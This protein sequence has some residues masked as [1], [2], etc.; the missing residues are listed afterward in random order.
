M[1]HLPT[2]LVLAAVLALTACNPQNSDPQEQTQRLSPTTAPSA[3]DHGQEKSRLI[4]GKNEIVSIL[5]NGMVVIC[6]RVASPAVT[7]RGYIRT[8]GVYE[9]KWLG[10]G[11]SHLLEHLVAGGSNQRRTEAQNRDLLQAIGNNSNAYTA[12]DRTACFVNTTPEHLEQAVDLV[13]GWVLGAKIT[14]A[15]FEREREVV[16][17]ELEMYEGMPD[18]VFA[19]L[20]Q[21]NRY[22]V[23]PARVPVIGCKEVIRRITRDDVY[24]YYKLAYQPNNMVFIVAGDL[25]PQ[26]M[27]RAVQK[28]V[29]DAPP[30]RAFSH[31]IE[32]E[33]LPAAPRTRLATFPNLGE[34]KLDLAFPGV[35]AGDPDEPALDLL[36]T[37]LGGGES[38]ILIQ[39]IRDKGLASSVSAGD[40]TPAYATGSFMVDMEM[41][42]DKIRAASDVALEQIEIVKKQGVSE[43]RLNRAKTQIKTSKAFARQTAGDVGEMMAV[44]FLNTGDV[45]F[46]DHYLQRVAQVT[47]EQIR[48]VAGKYLDRSRLLQTALMPQSAPGAEGLASA[49]AVLRSATATSRPVSSVEP[50]KITR[51]ELGDGTV[52]LV[53]RI[54]TAP[55]VVIRMYALGGV[56]A[57]DTA[58][59]GLGYLAMEAVPR[60]TKTRSARQ[61]A[62]FFDSIGGRLSTDSGNNA[63]SWSAICLKD[64]LRRTLEVFADVVKNPTF[65]DSEVAILQKRIVAAIDA[66]DADWFGQAMRFFRKTYFAP[67][68]SPYQFLPIGTKQNVEQ[69]TPIQAR[70]WYTQKILKSRR[71]LAIFGDVDT[72]QA[73]DL[74]AAL[75]GGIQ[76]GQW[77]ATATD[78][79]YPQPPAALPV[80]TIDVARVAVNKTANPQ[81]AVIVGFDS[82]SVPGDARDYALRVAKTMA[83]GYGYPTGYLFETLRG[84]GLVYDVQ[85]HIFYGRDRKCPGAFIVFAGCDPENVNRVA[86]AIIENIA[87]LQG[88]PQ[89]LQPRWF[90][91]SKLLITTS[92]ALAQETP[93]AQAETAAMDELYGLGYDY[94]D[95]FRSRIDAVKISQVP[96]LARDVLSCCVITVNTNMPEVVHITS[97]QR[98]YRAFKPV[99]LTP[100]GVQHDSAQPGR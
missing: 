42:A 15:E 63:W 49:S 18:D 52:L 25:D 82:N 44:D 66:Q 26:T 75:F 97:G 12:E 65:P 90:D 22:W 38:S 94:H 8:G 21:R 11:L 54:P 60:G 57:E 27:L 72:Q 95:Q 56:T 14:P 81:A 35:K 23:S 2:R 6:K 34:A 89:D 61:I 30:G 83:S 70:Q 17:R 53:K 33:P 9:G 45:H 4:Y 39:E 29:K 41:P 85:A 100:R 40:D 20:V 88:T 86:E 58:T 5:E 7:V 73:R 24:A 92:D 68:N 77:S 55:L 59:N 46:T 10:A 51:A 50:S 80:P 84:E 93:A 1:T 98:L 74:A 91:R 78:A 96:V 31:D 48:D 71:V 43:E 99:D 19:E 67:H 3:I 64:D 87:R 37:I 32:Q 28:Y 36:A 76:P 13:S 69:F 79:G 16:Q 62:E 47:P